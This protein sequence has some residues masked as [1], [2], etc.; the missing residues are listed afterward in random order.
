MNKKIKEILNNYLEF[1]SNKLFKK[2]DYLVIFGGSLRD[3]VSG[4]SDKIKDIDIMCLSKSRNIATDILL[5]EGYIRHDLFSPDIFM[6]YTNIKCIFEPKT[7][8]KGN[9]IV[10]LITP[11]NSN[12]NYNTSYGHYNAKIFNDMKSNFFEILQNVDL[13]T[14]GLVFDGE[15]LFESVRNSYYHCKNKYFHEITG[16]KMYNEDRIV[17]RKNNLYNKGFKMVRHDDI[18]FIRS[19]KILSIRNTIPTIKDLNIKLRNNEIKFERY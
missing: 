3:I 18:K 2:T 12:A 13:T 19:Q 10:Q 6:L 5:S 15:E 7:F 14:S 1:D 8:I 9:K 16:T 11:T 4:S 17:F